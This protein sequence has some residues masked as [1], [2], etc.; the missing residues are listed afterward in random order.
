MHSTVVRD[1]HLFRYVLT[2]CQLNLLKLQLLIFRILVICFSPK[3]SFS[4]PQS[5]K[6]SLKSIKTAQ[7]CI[8]SNGPITIAIRARFEYDS[9]TIRLRFG[10]N[11]LQHA[12]RFFVR[13]HTRSYTRIIVKKLN[14]LK[15]L[16]RTTAA[17]SHN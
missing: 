4:I 1:C 7:N 3:R 17:E 5:L 9:T 13:S 11:T 12:T 16:V 2:V 8:S 14:S 10:Y 6:C 15:H